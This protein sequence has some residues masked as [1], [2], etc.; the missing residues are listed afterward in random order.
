MQD[1]RLLKMSII[2]CSNDDSEFNDEIDSK[3]RFINFIQMKETDFVSWDM[4]ISCNYSI[5]EIIKAKICQ[6]FR[7]ILT[8]KY[9]Y[10]TSIYM[11]ISCIELER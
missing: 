6:F 5:S 9:S 7:W 3:T 11:K 4:Q 10:L 1:E 8:K 2:K